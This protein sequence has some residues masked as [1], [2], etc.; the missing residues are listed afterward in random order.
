MSL[1]GGA[2]PAKQSPGKYSQKTPGRLLRFARNDIWE[3]A[4]YRPTFGIDMML[5]T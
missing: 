4:M 3:E 5:F 2:F 1:R